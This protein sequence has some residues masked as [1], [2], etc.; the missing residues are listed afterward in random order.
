[1]RFRQVLMNLVGNAVKFTSD[2]GIFVK[3][4]VAAD[5]SSVCAVK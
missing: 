2:G 4:A 3:L 5:G 1:M